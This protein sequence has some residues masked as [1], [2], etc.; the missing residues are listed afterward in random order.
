MKSNRK[1]VIGGTVLVLF[2]SQLPSLRP[3]VADVFRPTE[4][5]SIPGGDFAAG[6]GL[7]GLDGGGKGAHRGVVGPAG[8]RVAPPQADSSLANQREPV[9]VNEFR[10]AIRSEDFDTTVHLYR[11]VLGFKP[12]ADWSGDHG[13]GVLLSV[14]A[15]T[16]EILSKEHADYVDRIELGSET[17]ARVRLA[18]SVEAIDRV[19]DGIEAAGAGRILASPKTTPWGDRSV[20]IGT[21]DEIQLTLFARPSPNK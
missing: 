8:G 3:A 5:A 9:M 4:Q 2:P 11:D 14:P 16:L 17:N 13:E 10:V 1:A 19:A 20:R 15:T 6:P 7:G 18:L 21:N 12:L